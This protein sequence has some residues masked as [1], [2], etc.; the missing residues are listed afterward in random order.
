MGA[1]CR[2]SGLCV[3]SSKA[4][5]RHLASRIQQNNI[6]VSD[7]TIFTLTNR[8]LATAAGLNRLK[9]PVVRP[10]LKSVELA[11]MERVIW[12]SCEIKHLRHV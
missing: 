8:P 1:C 9:Q 12:V 11:A 10:S 5:C 3:L 7:F 4:W 2:D 6:E